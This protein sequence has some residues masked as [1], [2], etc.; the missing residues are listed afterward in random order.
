MGTCG[1]GSP[2]PTVGQGKE[3]STSVRSPESNQDVFDGTDS[4]EVR[5]SFIG[6]WRKDPE[7]VTKVLIPGFMRT[8]LS[9]WSQVHEDFEEGG[10]SQ[11]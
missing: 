4:R 7:S 5:T 3:P 1:T 6:P 11:M 2:T 10:E 9:H 8:E